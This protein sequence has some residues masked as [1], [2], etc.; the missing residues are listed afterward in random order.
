MKTIDYRGNS[1]IRQFQLADML[2]GEEWYTLY[3]SEPCI[4]S[5]HDYTRASLADAIANGERIRVWIN[6][7]SHTQGRAVHYHPT[8]VVVPYNA[9]K[10]IRRCLRLAK[11]KAHAD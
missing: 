6:H 10:V 5:E 7:K 1:K 2:P 11:K 3:G 8:A 4:I 9:A